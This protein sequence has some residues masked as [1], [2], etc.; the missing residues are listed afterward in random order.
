MADLAQ[1][2]EFWRNGKRSQAECEVT[3]LLE[4]L[5]R[6]A[7]ALRFL[8]EIYGATDRNDQAIGLWRR[9]AAITPGDAG[10]L[11]QLAQALIAQRAFAEA[12]E[13]L[14]VAIR[15]EPTNARAYNN[16]GL[17]QLRSGDAAGA[18]AS[19]EHAVRIT[20]TYALAHMNLG[21]AHR[22]LNQI[23]LARACF[24]RALRLDPH[25]SSARSHLAELL[26]G[27]DE[28]AAR[29]ERDRAL[30]S[31]AI[32]L[33]T[34][35][36]HDE[37]I[38]VW[39]R[40][41]DEDAQLDYLIAMRFH[42]RLHCCDWSDYEA[43]RRRLQVE[44]MAG[45][46][47]DLPFSFF[48]YCDSAA[49]QLECA[50]LFVAARHPDRPA[51]APAARAHPERA[52][53][54]V[55]KSAR[56]R[57]A[58]VSSEFNEHATAYL[59]AGLLERHDRARFEIAALSYGQSDRS[60]MRTRIEASVERFF[61][62][63]QRTDREVVELMRSLEVDLA[64]DLKGL[65]GGARTGIFAQ[66]AAP[67]QINFLGYPGSTGAG[68]IDYVLADRHV[69]PEREQRYYSERVIYLP[70]CYQPNDPLRP[71]PRVASSRAELGLPDD[72]FVFCCFNNLYKISPATFRVWLGL[73]R[74]VAGSV[75]WLLGGTQTAMRNLRAV[76]AAGGIA[77]ERIC[78]APHI[79]QAHHLA[80]YLQADLFLDTT[81]CNA[82]TTASD[83]LW[84]GVPVLTL[85]GQAFAGRVA[86][87]LLHAVG[88]PQ[89]C[90][91]TV[92]EYASEALRLATE[93]AELAKLKAHLENGRQGFALF[94]TS[95]YCGHIEAAY[96]EIWNRHLRGEAPRALAVNDPSERATH[97]EQHS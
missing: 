93:P 48:V 15:L 32:N 14:R 21:L 36:R 66:R 11:R 61:D 30:E 13:R 3:A 50:R 73:L 53:V 72:G 22:A 16:L 31:H 88:L 24:E 19:L 81:P 83:A 49:A 54:T 74:R 2:L 18:A 43:L 79:P 87:S 86:T 60:A 26:L 20:P 40:L 65:S 55:A 29:R 37:A 17:A 9:L 58:Y 6:D 44:V 42:C 1:A 96:E 35:G 45:R 78:F 77:P 69:I 85:T 41:I 84:M 68:Y 80:R 71:L 23:A 7:A 90:T 82:H 4:A 46:R 5:P 95:A 38:Q 70:Q 76:A 97:E 51:A 34:V 64:V 57:V 47:A 94:D 27:S 10:V 28:S 33:M 59:I 92:D 75:L 25:L 12:I 39:D 89:L 63:S 62:I 56:L 52:P 67:V 8:A 91:R